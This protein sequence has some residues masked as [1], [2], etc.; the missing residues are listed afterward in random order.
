MTFLKQARKDF[1]ETFEANN[2]V[3]YEYDIENPKGPCVLVFPHPRYLRR[4]GVHPK[5]MTTLW[6]IGLNL[7]VIGNKGV[8]PENTDYIDDFIEQV[9]EILAPAKGV[10]SLGVEAPG[11]VTLYNGDYFGAVIEVEYNPVQT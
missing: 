6:T 2:I 9:L 7:I 3:A 1:K 8:K 10:V 5:T 11:V 4:Q